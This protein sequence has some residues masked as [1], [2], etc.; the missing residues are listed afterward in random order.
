MI[1][2][3]TTDPVAPHEVDGSVP[4]DLSEL[5]M[6]LLS[7][8]PRKRPPGNEVLKRLGAEAARWSV[9]SLVSSM[10][11]PPPRLVGRESQLGILVEQFERCQ[12]GHAVSVYVSGKSGMGKTALAQAF[13]ERLRHHGTALIFAGRC[14]ERESVP[15]KAFDPVIDALG[16][17]LARLPESEMAELLPDDYAALALFSRFSRPSTRSGAAVRAPIPR[18]ARA[19]AA[20][21]RRL[22]RVAHASRIAGAGGPLDRRSAVGRSRQRLAHALG[23]ASAQAPQGVLHRELSGRGP[24]ERFPRRVRCGA[25]A[26]RPR[27]GAH[28]RSPRSRRFAAADPG[29]TRNRF[30]GERP[31]GRVDCERV[32]RKPLLSRPSSRGR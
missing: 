8:D 21:V 6:L 10:S 20:G 7:R 24:P 31:A 32:R 28:G 30:F 4:R 2:K 23:V 12:K 25:P 29:G 27:P 18:F 14:Y 1:R 17:Y 16:R 13:L 26:R 11:S 9:P 3:C 22:A 5:C 19:A 15:F